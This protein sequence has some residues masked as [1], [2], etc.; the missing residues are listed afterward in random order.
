MTEEDWDFVLDVNLKGTFLVNQAVFPYLRD[1]GGGRIVNATSPVG[2]I[3]VPDRVNYS[4]SKGGV[5]SLSRALAA[6]WGPH[7][8]TVVCVSPVADTPMNDRQR[9]RLSGNDLA[10]YDARQRSN[11]L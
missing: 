7:G 2:F 10:A 5:T 8:I 9:A 3:A 6:E 4:A 11:P 1:N